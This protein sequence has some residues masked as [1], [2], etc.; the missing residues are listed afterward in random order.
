[1]ATNRCLVERQ[2]LAQTPVLR[3]H[4]SRTE[5]VVSALKPPQNYSAQYYQKIKKDYIIVTSQ[6]IRALLQSKV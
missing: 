5:F 3:V 2:L 4:A 6:T 1:M